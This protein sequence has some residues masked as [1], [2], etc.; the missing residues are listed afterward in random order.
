[1][2]DALTNVSTVGAEP[3]PGLIQFKRGLAFT[4]SLKLRLTKSLA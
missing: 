2:L 4:E 1:M 3:N